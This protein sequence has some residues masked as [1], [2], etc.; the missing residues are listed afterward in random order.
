MHDSLRRTA[1]SLSSRLSSE[2]I[3]T[4]LKLV[5]LGSAS[6]SHRP[7]TIHAHIQD[8]ANKPRKR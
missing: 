6:D 7:A 4:I 1:R 8:P 5:A 3:L 2:D